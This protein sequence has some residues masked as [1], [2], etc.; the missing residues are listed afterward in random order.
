MCADVVH[1]CTGL[2]CVVPVVCDT[3]DAA[4]VCD[5]TAQVFGRVNYRTNISCTGV[6]VA[7]I[8]DRFMEE[9]QRLQD[10]KVP[11]M[12][13]LISETYDPNEMTSFREERRVGESDTDR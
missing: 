3:V 2:S 7:V 6:I 1:S 9:H 8:N 11:L 12:H 10:V 13:K 5:E 4:V